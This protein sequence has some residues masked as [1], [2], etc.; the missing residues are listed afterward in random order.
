MNSILQILEI[1]SSPY[2]ESD[3]ENGD[4]MVEDLILEEHKELQNDFENAR[5]PILNDEDYGNEI[6]AVIHEVECKSLQGDCMG[7]E[8]EDECTSIFFVGDIQMTSKDVV[9]CEGG[10]KYFGS[11]PKEVHK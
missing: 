3:L 7:E 9:S 6:E 2:N 10:D 11:D 8:M 5:N 4:S 1:P